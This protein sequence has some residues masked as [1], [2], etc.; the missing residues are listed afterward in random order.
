MKTQNMVVDAIAP[1]STNNPTRPPQLLWLDS[2]RR[3]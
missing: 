3:H 2:K 1:M